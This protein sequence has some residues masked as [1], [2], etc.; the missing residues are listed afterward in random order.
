MVKRVVIVGGGIAGLVAAFRRASP[1]AT[2][3]L[4]SDGRLGGSIRTIREDGFVLEAGPNTLRT[5]AAADR[6]ITDI[7]LEADLVLAG[8]RAPRWIVRGG[9][10]RAIVPGPRGLVSSVLSARGKLRLL[11]ELRAPRRAPSLEDESVHDF[12]VR[13]FGADAATYGAGPM[14]SGVYAGDA[15]NLSVRSAF[16]HL[17]DAEAHSGSVI[18]DYIAGGLGFGRRGPTPLVPPDPPGR[19]HR[20]RTINFTRGLFQMIEAL[21]MKLTD[22]GARIET[23]AAV[24]RLEGP[25]PDLPGRRWSL[26]TSDGRSFDADSVVVTLDPGVTARLLG[27]RLPRSGAA[28]AALPVSPVA[29]VIFAFRPPT[30]EDAPKGFGVLVPRVEGIRSLGV[31]YPASLFS[32]RAP[33]GIALTTSFLGGALDPE[34]AAADDATLGDLALS[35]V[36]RLHPGLRRCV[37]EKTWITRWPRAIPQLPLGHFR[38]MEALDEDLA[39]V[40][41]RAGATGTLVLTGGWRDGIALGARI[42]RGEAIGRT[43]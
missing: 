9:R 4:E 22:A 11:G 18:R 16:P 39:E 12:F 26:R 17:W 29:T 24:V 31:L 41:R 37:P 38:T 3:I 2:V 35:E 5:T 36:R 23:N 8:R 34:I 7:G 28:V 14:V 33:A 25:R 27:D 32:S 13:R 20:A 43:L 40:D 6:L 21:A 30:P 1:G 15:M 10:P 42:D 19:R